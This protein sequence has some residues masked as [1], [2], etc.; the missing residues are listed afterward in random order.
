[1]NFLEGLEEG[2]EF[3]TK[4]TEIMRRNHGEIPEFFSVHS[5]AQWF[6]NARG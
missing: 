2:K 1:M 5:V 3:R 6:D 4:V